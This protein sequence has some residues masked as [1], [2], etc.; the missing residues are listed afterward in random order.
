L[1]LPTI[2][3]FSTTETHDNWATGHTEPLWALS[4]R[5]LTYVNHP[6]NDDTTMAQWKFHGLRFPH[7]TGDL[8]NHNDCPAWAHGLAQGL[9]LDNVGVS[10]YKMS[11]GRVLPGHSDTYR[12]YKKVLGIDHT[13]I[14]RIVVFLEDWQ[15]GHILEVDKRLVT[16]WKAGDWVGWRYDTH[17]LAANLGTTDRYTMQI[18]GTYEDK[19]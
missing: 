11:P 17:H 18:T 12:M 8:I 14:F 16:G 3:K 1:S 7:Y 2:T 6:Y 9:G 19:E 5:E 4:H 13:R 10:L 15:S